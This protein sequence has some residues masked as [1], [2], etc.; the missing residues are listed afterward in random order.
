MKKHYKTFDKYI[1]VCSISF[2]MI[3]GA[4]TSS[5]AAFRLPFM[6]Q[7]SQSLGGKAITPTSFSP[8]GVARFERETLPF[9]KAVGKFSLKGTTIEGPTEVKGLLTVYDAHLKDVRVDGLLKA[10]GSMMQEITL[11]GNAEFKRCILHN[12][13]ITGRAEL[14]K[15][16]IKGEAYITGFLYSEESKFE[17]TLVAV[18]NKLILTNST[19]P[20]IIVKPMSK[21]PLESPQVIRL[22]GKTI[23][24]GGIAFEQ[25]GGLVQADEEAIIKGA[26]KGGSLEKRNQAKRKG[27]V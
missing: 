4:L 3:L 18:G 12:I 14:K 9:L 10:T 13:N 23:V 24:D 15:S 21:A 16:T 8:L 1:Q 5:K 26:I 11:R 2:A 20:N 17:K 27:A 7:L 19:V 6:Q 22:K 25:P